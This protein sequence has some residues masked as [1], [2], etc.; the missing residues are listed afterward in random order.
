MSETNAATVAGLTENI[1]RYAFEY[2]CAV[3]M[4][5]VSRWGRLFHEA[6]DELA[7]LT[8]KDWPMLHARSVIQHEAERIEGAAYSFRA[9]LGTLTHP[10]QHLGPSGAIEQE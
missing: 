4:E 7:A 10:Q 5:D 6:L 1:R 3:H 9:L 2:R 8:G